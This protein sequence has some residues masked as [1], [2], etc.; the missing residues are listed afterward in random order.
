MSW[1]VWG[2]ALACTSACGFEHGALSGDAGAD[3]P[4]D[5][6]TRFASCK[7]IHAASPSA[8]SGTYIIDPDGAG[9][10]AELSV[11]CDMTTDGGGWTIVFFPG[12]ANVT[13]VPPMYTRS[14]PT[15]LN[16]ATDALM[17][18][19]DSNQQA[20]T[21]AASFPLPALWRTATPFSVS[22]MDV[23]TSVQV[24][25]GTATSALLRFGSDSFSNTCS[26]NWTGGTPW[27]RICIVGTLAPYYT[28]F[29]V[30]GQDTCS[31]SSQSWNATTCTN[32]RRFSIAVR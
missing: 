15:L 12:T 11:T 17:A 28:G 6:A 26:D 24:D 25:G 18:Y 1:R 23:T 16:N 21:N 32:D 10:E 14:T 4:P 27:G 31:N 5:V 7:A 13:G 19:R 8:T 3:A 22:S 30:M 20:L 9:P 29:A 2:L